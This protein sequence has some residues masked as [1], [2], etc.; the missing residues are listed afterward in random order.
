MAGSAGLITYNVFK[1]PAWF[2]IFR[3]LHHPMILLTLMA[4]YGAKTN[5]KA[6]IGGM[7]GGFTV[8]LLALWSLLLFFFEHFIDLIYVF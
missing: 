5:D 7:A 8:F 2:N 1:N 6:I 4:F 3:H